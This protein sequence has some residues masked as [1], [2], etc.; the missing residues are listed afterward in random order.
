MIKL[1]GLL[2]VR[3]ILLASPK[4]GRA[5]ARTRNGK[6]TG[7]IANMAGLGHDI[8]PET[9]ELFKSQSTNHGWLWDHYGVLWIG[10]DKIHKYNITVV[11]IDKDGNYKKET[12]VAES[13][14][15][16]QSWPMIISDEL[17]T[18][19][20]IELVAKV[21]LNLI[22]THA[23]L[24]MGHQPN[25]SI[26]IDMAVMAAVRDFCGSHSIDEVFSRPHEG[27]IADHT[28]SKLI[29]LIL[30]LN[31]GTEGNPGL[32][33]KIGMQI[34]S[35]NLISIDIVDE[36]VKEQLQ[37]KFNAEQEGKARVTTAEAD[38]Q[39]AEKELLA[40]TKRAEALLV[41]KQKEAEGVK[42]IG[43]AKNAVLL[44]RVE[45]FGNKPEL[46]AAIMTAEGYQAGTLVFGDKAMILGERK[47]ET[48]PVDKKD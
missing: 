41:E 44:K 13:L 16:S 46:L 25:W 1:A 21:N 7:Y 6:I 5:M 20:G 45:A 37:A 15:L 24:G 3:T 4:I 27:S 33:D 32:K 19:E 40:R 18:K 29:D 17:K 12:V 38:V 43:D 48:R 30:S 35:F 42:A 26:V 39:V 34:A 10:F 28:K 9:G 47:N 22:L 11:K 31:N 23:G 36:K 14:F 2:A 8:I